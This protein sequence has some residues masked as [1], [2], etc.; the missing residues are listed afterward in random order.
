MRGPSVTRMRKKLHEKGDRYIDRH[1]DLANYLKSKFI[2]KYDIFSLL[3]F[4]ISKKLI[5]KAQGEKGEIRF[6]CEILGENV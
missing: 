4:F 6:F 2:Y 1:C 5:N 3:F